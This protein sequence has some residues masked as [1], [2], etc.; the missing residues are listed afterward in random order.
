MRLQQV[1]LALVLALLACKRAVYEPRLYPANAPPPATD[2]EPLKAHL[3]SGD[4]L[5]FRSWVETDAALAGQA[6]RYGPDR[7]L[8]ETGRHYS[9]PFDSMALLE[10]H[11]R[12]GSR[13]TGV[14]GMA[15]WSVVAGAISLACISDPKSCFGSCPTFYVAT[16]TGEALAAEGF[17]ASIARVLEATDLDALHQARS[18]GG[19]FT[20]TMRNE[21]LE[22]HAVRRLHLVG[23]RRPRDGQVFSDPKGRFHPARVLVR[24][25]GCSAPEGSCLPELQAHDGIERTSLADSLDLAARDTVELDFPPLSGRL[26]VVLATRQSL[27]STYLFYQTM[28]FLGS[29]AGEAL[30]ALERGGAE[31]ANA[32]MGM[33]RVVG[34]MDLEVWDGAEWTHVGT[35]REAGPLAT[36]V[37]VYPLGHRSG[38][39]TRA[40]LIAP[41][42]AWRLDWAAIAALDEPVAPIRVEASGVS[43]RGVPDTAALRLLRDPARHLVT[44]PGEV[45]EIS[46]DLPPADGEWQLF[47]ESEGYYYEWM[48]SE[49]LADENPALAALALNNP[50]RALRMFAR[51]FKRAEPEME[52]RFWNSRFRR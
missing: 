27:L 9:V 40:R 13:P 20:L 6:E 48:R 16:D 50:T 39:P 44:Y 12:T 15:V 22:T 51:D 38:G 42:G 35:H 4:V 33:A 24:P 17:S 49:W 28:G 11:V 26:G 37:T 46:F 10:M 45:Y 2:R 8:T 5:V 52:R 43:R 47:L 30:A 31:R 3:R 32:A 41:K 7:R 14:A 19:R 1:G 29:Q 18:T 25:S 23:T 21:A 34:V 36:N